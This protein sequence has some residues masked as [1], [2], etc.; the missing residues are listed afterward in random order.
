MTLNQKIKK[1]KK[2]K[3]S[4]TQANYQAVKQTQIIS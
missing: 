3:K 2:K 1:F 4:H